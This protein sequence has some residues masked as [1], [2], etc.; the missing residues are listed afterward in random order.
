MAFCKYSSSLINS[1]TISIDAKFLNDY[2]A[3][4]PDECLK[5]YLFG[6]LKCQNSAGRDNSIDN[7]V[8]VLNLSK[9]DVMKRTK[10]TNNQIDF[11]TKL[12]AFE[13]MSEENQLSLFDFS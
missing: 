5:V 12:G 2:L 6:L 13:N 10:L 4:A 9:E 3:I 7:F 8:N 1:E 11:L